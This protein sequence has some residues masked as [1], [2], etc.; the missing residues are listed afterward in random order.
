MQSW[1]EPDQEVSGL[2]PLARTHVL[3]RVVVK[4]PARLPALAPPNHSITGKTVRFD[5]YLPRVC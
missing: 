3:E 1:I 5:V 2:L 4:W